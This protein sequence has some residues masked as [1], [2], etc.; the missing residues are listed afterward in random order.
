MICA[1]GLRL[2][3]S[4][5]SLLLSSSTCAAASGTWLQVDELEPSKLERCSDPLE[6]AIRFLVP[7]QALCPDNMQSHTLAYQIYS[8]KDK[9]LLM[10]KAIKGGH[11]ALKKRSATSSGSGDGSTDDPAFHVCLV[12]FLH[13]YGT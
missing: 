7:L 4:E 9:P 12:K 11:A 3:L 2:E 5:L 8:R 10:L 13:Y 1:A 6:Q